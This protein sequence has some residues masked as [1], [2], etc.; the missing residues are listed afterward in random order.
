MRL[1]FRWLAALAI[2]VLIPALAAAQTESGKISGT[3]TDQSGAVLPG[4]NVTAKSVERATTRSTVTNA[5][6]EYVFAGLVPGQYEVTAELSGFA[7]KQ[8]KTTV[9]VGATVAVNIGMSVGQQTE[10]VTVVGETAAAINTST[11]DIAT[12]AGGTPL[13]YAISWRPRTIGMT[14]TWAR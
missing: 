14:V 11:Q 6:G 4:V 12:P 8:T 7:T 2:V 1:S 5:Q 9:A 10:V 3:V 13:V